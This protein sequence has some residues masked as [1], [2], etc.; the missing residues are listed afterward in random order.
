MFMA[1]YTMS[2]VQHGEY[3]EVADTK[4]FLRLTTSIPRVVCHF[5]HPDMPR[6]AI[7]DRHLKQ[8][9]YCPRGI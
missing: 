6:C 4:E 2:C 5:Y 8:V 9:L 7:I 1:C 3:T